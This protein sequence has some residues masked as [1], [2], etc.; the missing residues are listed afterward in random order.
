MDALSLTHQKCEECET[1]GSLYIKEEKPV[2]FSCI[3][4]EGEWSVNADGSLEQERFD[5][6]KPYYLE[7]ME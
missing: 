1:W 4:C 3:H 7:E 6:I 5:N 2:L